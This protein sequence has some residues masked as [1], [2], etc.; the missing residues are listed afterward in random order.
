MEA[1]GLGVF[2]LSAGVFATLL[3]YHDS[4]LHQTLPDPNL[5]RVLMGLAMGITAVGIIYSP[6][7][8][9]SGAHINPAVTLTF[10]RLG[11]VAP[12]DALFYIGAQFAG[13]F[14]GVLLVITFAGQAFSDPQVNYVVTAPGPA[15]P[16]VA[17]VSELL[18]SFGL[19]G[20]VL[21][22]TNTPRLA[23]FTGLFAG[24]VV[25]LYIAI[26]AP[27]SGMS[28]NPARTLASALPAREWTGLWLYFTA[29]PSACCS[30]PK[31]MYG[32]AA[33]GQSARP[34]SS[35]TTASAAYSAV[36]A[37]PIDP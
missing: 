24:A 27:L 3:E 20:V 11:K 1:A 9:Q 7:G 8:K 32:W 37:T 29:P 12:A 4:P 5:R 21:F 30:P 25:A 28:M 36:I 15:G 14:A 34:S 16:S 31:A 19:M 33:V 13:G 22:A 26:E 2:M 35:T 10:W 23:P 6:W 17:F 18:I